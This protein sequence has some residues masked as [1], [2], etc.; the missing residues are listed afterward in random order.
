MRACL[1]LHLTVCILSFTLTFKCLLSCG[2][3]WGGWVKGFEKN[4]VEKGQHNVTLTAEQMFF[5]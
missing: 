2:R 4:C 5:S 1:C 3:Q